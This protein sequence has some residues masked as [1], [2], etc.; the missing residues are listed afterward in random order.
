M[1]REQ[2][3]TQ[4][5]DRQES[6]LFALKDMQSRLTAMRD[7]AKSNVL[8]RYALGTFAARIDELANEIKVLNQVLLATPE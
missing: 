6:L 7:D 4:I 2:L 3:T 1:T 8:P 5:A